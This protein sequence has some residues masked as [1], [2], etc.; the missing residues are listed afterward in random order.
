MVYRDGHLAHLLR[1]KVVDH[2]ADRLERELDRAQLRR[3]FGGCPR[4][5]SPTLMHAIPPALTTTLSGP[6][7]QRDAN[8]LCHNPQLG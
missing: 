1:G 7:P 3:R 8:G 2:R 4:H 5:R 6:T